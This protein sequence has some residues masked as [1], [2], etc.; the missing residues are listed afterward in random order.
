MKNYKSLT[1]PNSEYR[2]HIGAAN[3]DLLLIERSASDYIWSRNA[4]IDESK[5]AAF[6][7][8]TALHT[9]L[10]EPEKFNA[11]V[12]IYSQTKTRETKAFQ[13]FLAEHNEESKIILLESE[14][15]KLRFTVDG[16][17]YHP[18]VNRLLTCPSDKESSI[19][20]NDKAR[21][22]VRKIRP[23]LDYCNH[24][25]LLL[26]DAKSTDKI[27]DW[28]EYAPWKNPFLTRNYVHTA[29]YYMDTASIFYGE[30][31]NE[32]TFIVIQKHIEMGRYPVAAIK[33]TREELN[34]LGAFDQMNYN[35]DKYANCLHSNDWD[36]VERFPLFNNKFDDDIEVTLLEG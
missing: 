6:D 14:Y 3:S 12:V 31:I 18:T 17:K 24:G 19:F 23:D 13:D 8:G 2:D 20:V 1:M 25:K 27:S 30:Q 15:D 33:I 4:P 22:I 16:A 26:A 10:L 35:L 21:D 5:T 9:A 11:Q 28:R 34:G 32:Y 7:F 29:A 36:E